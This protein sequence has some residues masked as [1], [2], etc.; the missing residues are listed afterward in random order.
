MIPK[1]SSNVILCAE[2]KSKKDFEFAIVDV[3]WF[4]KLYMKQRLL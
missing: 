3:S 2:M 4:W 1:N